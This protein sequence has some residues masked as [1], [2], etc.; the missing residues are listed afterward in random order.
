MKTLAYTLLFLLAFTQTLI[1]GGEKPE[2]SPAPRVTGTRHFLAG[3]QWKLRRLDIEGRLVGIA[4]DRL[5]LS[6]HD[7]TVIGKSFCNTI[8]AKFRIRGEAI[9]FYDVHIK[10]DRTCGDASM[11]FEEEYLATL[12]SIVKVEMT[13]ANRIRFKDESCNTVATLSMNDNVEPV[14]KAELRTVAVK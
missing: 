8:Q 6:F 3:T 11:G 7:S 1:A 5:H 12:K 10:S 4:N 9:T 14:F 13:S 2:P